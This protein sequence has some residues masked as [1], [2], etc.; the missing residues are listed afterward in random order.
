MRNR[1]PLLVPLLLIAFGLHLYQI[2]RESLW[3]DEVDSLR[4]AAESWEKLGSSDSL[5][6]AGRELAAYL[7]RPGWNGPLYFLGLEPWLRAAGRSELALRFPSAAVAL[8]GVALCFAVGRR[9]W[10]NWPAG[11][12]ATLLAAANPYLAWYAGEGK[13]YALLTA[14]A[15]LSTYLLVRALAGGGGRFWLAYVLV[16]TALLYVHILTPLILPVHALLALLLHPRA[17]RSLG[18]V[19][20]G[21]AL[22][23]PYVPLLIW[24]WPQ[25]VEPAETGFARASLFEMAWRQTEAFSRGI[26][27]WPAALPLALWVGAAALGLSMAALSSGRA[28]EEGRPRVVLALLGWAGLPLIALYLISLRRPLFTERYLIWTLPAWWLLIAGGLVGLARRGRA[29]RWLATAWTA[30]LVVV[31]LLGIGQQWATPVRADFRAAAAHVAHEYEPAELVLFQ[32]PYLQTTFD[33]YAGRLDY[34]A[35]EGPY[36]N[37]GNPPGE[38]DAYLEEITAGHPHVWLVLSEAAMWDARGLTLAWFREH[39]QL[40]E[41]RAFNRVTVSRWDLSER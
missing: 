11:A 27:G 2:D 37:Y 26:I 41:E 38:T 18:A 30:A 28:Q 22:T 21:A 31:G 24:Q 23:L 36:T 3:R 15:L 35:A 5:P 34:Q 32:I 19:L 13:M 25:L 17:V 10:G 7:T 29:E 9:L 14:L 33:Y 8:I 39:A 4:F 16:T 1:L 6:A 12:L 40:E 20:A